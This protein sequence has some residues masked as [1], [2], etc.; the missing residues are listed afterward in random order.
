M[1]RKMAQVYLTALFF[2]FALLTLNESAHA[3]TAPMAC[4]AFLSSF[5]V[6][7]SSDP[8]LL[9]APALVEDE[10]GR[11]RFSRDALDAKFECT[12]GGEISQAEICLTSLGGPEFADR[13]R[14]FRAVNRAALMATG[15]L[16]E[17]ADTIFHDLAAQARELIFASMAANER[18]AKFEFS[19]STENGFHASYRLIQEEI[20]SSKGTACFLME[21]GE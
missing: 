20:G 3:A 21:R 4:S 2:A 14:N 7:A 18:S 16:E 9:E 11:F 8:T 19:A 17:N 1:K 10:E 6:L 15:L 12:A 5:E 13:V